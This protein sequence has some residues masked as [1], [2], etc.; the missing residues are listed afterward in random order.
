MGL[1]GTGKTTLTN[2]LAP[3]LNAVVFNA[4]AIRENINKDLGFTNEDR[5][6]QARRMGW[7][8]DRVTETN[9]NAIA[10]FICPTHETRNAFGEAFVVWVD[11]IKEGRFEDTNKL[12]QPPEQ[13]DLRVTEEGNPQYWA[14]KALALYETGV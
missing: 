11:R 13:Y 1:S 10:D 8:C 4:D 3:H 9:N 7:L 5:I 6:E 2:A 12:F 14:Q